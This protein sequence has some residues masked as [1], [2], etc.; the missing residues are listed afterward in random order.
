MS[1]AD[2]WGSYAHQLRSASKLISDSRTGDTSVD[3]TASYS[4]PRKFH[5]CIGQDFPSRIQIIRLLHSIVIAGEQCLRHNNHCN[6]Q[7]QYNNIPDDNAWNDIRFLAFEI[8]CC[9]HQSPHKFK[10]SIVLD[11]SRYWM[12]SRTDHIE[13]SGWNR[14]VPYIERRVP[15]GLDLCRNLTQVIL[16]PND[17]L[18]RH[19][20]SPSWT[21]EHLFSRYQSRQF[22][23]ASSDRRHPAYTGSPVLTSEATI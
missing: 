2:K 8:Y 7:A 11:W 9:L 14:I 5:R 12:H 10:A 19:L 23:Y 13:P 18:L 1:T 16:L 21:P 22:P 4:T 3:W 20:F 6:R 15:K 17:T